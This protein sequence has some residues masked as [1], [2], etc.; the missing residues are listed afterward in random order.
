LEDVR[1][2]IDADAAGLMRDRGLDVAV[3]L[4]AIAGGEENEETALYAICRREAEAE[5]MRKIEAA[6]EAKAA[7]EK[8]VV[9]S[10]SFCRRK[11]SDWES[12]R[13]APRT[14]Q[15]TPPKLGTTRIRR[16]SG[17]QSRSLVHTT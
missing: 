10:H 5:R 14:I 13:A 7:R 11:S 2:Q 16:F 3:A 4:R 1:E 8:A 9:T 15:L 6:A 12:K 17:D